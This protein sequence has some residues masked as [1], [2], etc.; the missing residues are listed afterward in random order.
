[1]PAAATRRAL[2]SARSHQRQRA[3][4]RRAPASAFLIGLLAC[5]S[6]FVMPTRSAAAR[7]DQA[8]ATAK[9]L[10]SSSDHDEIE[11]GIQSLG[12]IGSAA[13]V[14]PLVDRVRLGLPPDLLEISIVTLMAL[15][16]PQAAPLFFELI[17]HRRP[18][19]RVRAIEAIVALKPQGAEPFLQKALADQNPQVR[20]AAALALGELKAT[21][22]VELLFQ[23]LDHGNFEASVA[24]GQALRSDHVPRLLGYLGTVPF[25]SLAPALTEILQRKDI[26]E[27]DKLN[28]VSRVQD[29]GTR[30]VKNYF[31]D[32]MRATGDKLPANVSR[33]VLRAMQEIAE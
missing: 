28:V 5:A 7:G 30:E 19:I 26:S 29:V 15:G 23:A 32:V 11:T 9:A 4:P 31:G 21:S 8:M 16:Q 27:R 24:I 12:L 20:S 22:S 3:Q 2:P 6:L 17:E 14:G 1:M 18:E 10:L 13:A 25:H 33:A